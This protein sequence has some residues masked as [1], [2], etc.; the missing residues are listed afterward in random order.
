MLNR[1]LW[2]EHTVTA[3]RK[4]MLT[5]SKMEA[6]EI[7]MGDGKRNSNPNPNPTDDEARAGFILL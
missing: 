1:S 4:A 3:L 7:M 6:S 5:V 2:G